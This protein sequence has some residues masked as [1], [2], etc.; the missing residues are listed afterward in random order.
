MPG[1]LAKI[2]KLRSC[3]PPASWGCV[4]K[5]E[6]WVTSGEADASL[7]DG[8][9]RFRHTHGTQKGL[10]KTVGQQDGL[11]HRRGSKICKVSQQTIIRCFDSGQLKDS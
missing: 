5:E 9:R 2:G 10:P 1:A 8:W 6:G 3:L 4:T 11:H 7:P